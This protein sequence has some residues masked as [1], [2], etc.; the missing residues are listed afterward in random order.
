MSKRQSD[1][2]LTEAGFYQ[3][4]QSM[5]F[6]LRERQSDKCNR[7]EKPLDVSNR[8]KYNIHHVDENIS[9]NS[10]ENLVLLCVPCHRKIHW[11]NGSQPRDR[12]GGRI[13][14]YLGHTVQE[15]RAAGMG[16]YKKLRPW[17]EIKDIPGA[18]YRGLGLGFVSVHS[19]FVK[20]G[21]TMQEF[22]DFLGISRNRVAQLM[23]KNSPRI[24]DAKARMYIKNNT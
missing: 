21:Y 8:R 7:C 5:V 6:E 18:K 13:K 24:L 16:D 9:N 17:D 11:D 10:I 12:V 1:G 3:R 15:L 20:H 22:A 19:C 14:K 4:A 2:S 23:A